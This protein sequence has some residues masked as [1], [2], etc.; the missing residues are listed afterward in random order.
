[1]LI[2]LNNRGRREL[3]KNKT[4]P[5]TNLSFGVLVG[6]GEDT[7]NGLSNDADLCYFGTCAAGRLLYA[8]L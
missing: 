2:K 6:D 3:K 4:P 5:R 1:M 8:Q 7:G